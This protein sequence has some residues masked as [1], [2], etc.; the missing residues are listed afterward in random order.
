MMNTNLLRINRIEAITSS[1]VRIEIFMRLGLQFVIV[2]IPK[3]MHFGRDIFFL[4]I[5]DYYNIGQSRHIF[6]LIQI[7]LQV[8]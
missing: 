1:F 7:C 4:L 3:V 5:N 2:G 8:R 6:N